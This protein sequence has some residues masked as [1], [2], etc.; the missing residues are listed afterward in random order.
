MCSIDFF[1]VIVTNSV[2][3]SSTEVEESSA[4][5]NSEQDAADVSNATGDGANFSSTN[6]IVNYL[7]QTLSDD[8]FYNLFS[9]IGTLTNHKVVRDPKTGYCFGYGFANYATAA[10][11]ATAITKLNGLRLL[12][13]TLKVAYARPKS[14]KTKNCNLYL[15]GLP[16]TAD[17]ALLKEL[18]S[19]YGT[20]INCKVLMNQET[21]KCAGT[22]FILLA[23]TTECTAAINAL[24]NTKPQGFLRNLEVQFAYSSDS[25]AN[26]NQSYVPPSNQASSAGPMRSLKANH[27]RNKP[28]GHRLETGVVTDPSLAQR[29]ELGVVIFV[30]NF[31]LTTD[32]EKLYSLF[33]PFGVIRKVN[34]MRNESGHPRG[35]GF[36]TMANDDEAV[37]AVLKLNRS[38]YEDRTIEVRFKMAEASANAIHSNA[39]IP[40]QNSHIDPQMESVPQ[41]ADHMYDGPIYNEREVFSAPK[42]M[43]RPPAAEEYYADQS[44]W[45]DRYYS[46]G[47]REQV[48]PFPIHNRPVG[49]PIGAGSQMGYPSQTYGQ[50]MPRMRPP[51]SAPV[52]HYGHGA[53]SQTG[54]PHYA[55]PSQRRPQL[56]P[57]NY[58]RDYY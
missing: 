16:L 6:L 23:T 51:R 9:A 25:K 53:G 31:P 54:R 10:D 43:Y 1:S 22:G 37:R 2:K 32:E 28:L 56:T 34:V 33:S 47:V 24:N 3:M 5:G 21:M 55:L 39:Q 45:P 7:P 48:P 36:V 29:S 17:E 41:Y 44:Y 49:N 13:K 8:A 52:R 27:L 15:T 26:V 4:A 30:R 11:A 42:P 18:F 40:S 58:E 57:L 50:S 35:Y 38:T 12:N 20:V 19:P 46:P 14:E